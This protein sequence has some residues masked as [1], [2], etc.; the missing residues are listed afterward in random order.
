MSRGFGLIGGTLVADKVFV[1]E[2]LGR[3]IG[4]LLFSPDSHE[5]LEMWGHEMGVL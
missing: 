3:R 1:T 5:G 2:T 4:H